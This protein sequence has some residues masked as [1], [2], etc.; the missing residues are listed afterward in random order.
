M[1]PAQP[2]TSTTST[3]K[4][5]GRSTVKT[6]SLFTTSTSTIPSTRT[7]V[8]TVTANTS[9]SAVDGIFGTPPPS[10]TVG[11]SGTGTPIFNN[12]TNTTTT[13][14]LETA[15]GSRVYVSYTLTVPDGTGAHRPTHTLPTVPVSDGSKAK[16]PGKGH[17]GSTIA[18][19]VMMLAMLAAV[20]F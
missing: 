8:K 2:S 5:P 7:S 19:C 10:F 18:Y 1:T 13:V 14:S 3:T 9:T 11:P 12:S 4:T 6:T 20:L 16:P 15:S 17:D